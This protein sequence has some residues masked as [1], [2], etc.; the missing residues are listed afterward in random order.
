[1]YVYFKGFFVNMALVLIY[2]TLYAVL[3][4]G[5][6]GGDIAMFL[7]SILT[8]CIQSGILIS[9]GLKNKKRLLANLAG[10]VIGFVVFCIAFRIYLEIKP[11]VEPRMVDGNKHVSR[12]TTFDQRA[13]TG[14]DKTTAL[15]CHGLFVSY[16]SLNLV[17]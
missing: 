5:V 12:Q 7:L 9:I 4:K 15:N 10:V 17:F 1:M 11:K 14:I 2:S 13:I 8:M 16:I 6:S 3:A